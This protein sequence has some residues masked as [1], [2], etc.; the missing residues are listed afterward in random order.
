MLQI[1]FGVAVL[2]YPKASGGKMVVAQ[3]VGHRHATNHSPEKLWPLQHAGGDQQSAI[4][5]SHDGARPWAAVTLVD[6]P[7]GCSDEVIEHLLFVRQH[8]ALVPGFPIFTAA[9]QVGH[10]DDASELKP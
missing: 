7:L 3:H 5:T 4:A 9:A 8:A 10:R 2:R 6:E 1:G